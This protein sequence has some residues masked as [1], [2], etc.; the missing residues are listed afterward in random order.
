MY[1]NRMSYIVYY[2]GKH[3]L[4]KLKTLPVDIS[5]ISEKLNYLILY[6]DLDQEQNLK[7]QLKNVKGFRQI[8]K[9]NLYDK[10]LNF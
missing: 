8:V 10:E 9:S 4:E 5:F 6:A 7:R 1:A 2:N 3:V